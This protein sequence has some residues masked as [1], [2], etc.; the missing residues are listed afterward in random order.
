MTEEGAI[1]S[2]PSEQDSWEALDGFV[3]Q[4]GVFKE[5]FGIFVTHLVG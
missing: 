3:A 1:G 4:I 5:K 2:E